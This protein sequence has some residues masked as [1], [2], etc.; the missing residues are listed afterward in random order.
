MAF[1]GENGDESWA[2]DVWMRKKTLRG[3]REKGSFSGHESARAPARTSLDDKK[4]VLAPATCYYQRER[5]GV[6]DEGCRRRRRS[7]AFPLGKK[8]KKGKKNQK[9]IINY[10]YD[11][12]QYYAPKL[13]AS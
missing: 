2:G 12:V 11:S 3:V 1:S 5:A 7:K 8:N 13:A 6:S 10:A 4:R 9:T